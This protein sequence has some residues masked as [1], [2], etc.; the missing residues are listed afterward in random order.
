M[1]I[2]RLQGDLVGW[3]TTMPK[4][5]QPGKAIENSSLDK[6]CYTTLML[7]VEFKPTAS[8][9]LSGGVIPRLTHCLNHWTTFFQD[10][11]LNVL[12]KTG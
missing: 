5:F 6:E 12:N 7:A 3:G 11:Y 1:A 10:N 2:N 9:S 4:H 8:Q